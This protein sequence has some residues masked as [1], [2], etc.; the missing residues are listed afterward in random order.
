MTREKGEA[1]VGGNQTHPTI[2]HPGLLFPHIARG[3]VCVRLI[4]SSPR[5]RLRPDLLGHGIH[6]DVAALQQPRRSHQIHGH[7]DGMV[8][9]TS[10]V[11]KGVQIWA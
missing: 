3:T 5:Q 7:T 1:E 9:R 8:I 10:L 6:L 11:R 2:Q 4:S